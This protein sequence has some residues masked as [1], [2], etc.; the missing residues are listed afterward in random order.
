MLPLAD[1]EKIEKQFAAILAA[2]SAKQKKRLLAAMGSPPDI[3]N[4]PAELWEEI[5]REIDNAST[6]LLIL[7]YIASMDGLATKGPRQGGIGLAVDETEAAR[8]A[9]AWGTRRATEMAEEITETTRNRLETAARGLES[10]DIS[11]GRFDESVDAVFSD[12]RAEGIATTETSGAK[13]NGEG[14]Y[15]KQVEQEHKIVLLATWQHFAPKIIGRHPCP[16]IC[17]PLE[18]SP[19]YM[20]QQIHPDIPAA[21][22]GPPAHPLCDCNLSYRQAR[23]NE[24]ALLGGSKLRVFAG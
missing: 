2:A 22:T 21:W 24:I 15:R 1:R 18:R 19:E 10:G 4:V 3:A 12:K 5:K 7:V 16:E 23:D 17:R 9:Q 6:E 11:R 13:T 20:W 14:G 8:R